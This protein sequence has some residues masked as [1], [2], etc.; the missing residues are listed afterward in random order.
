MD[1]SFPSQRTEG[2]QP[3]ASWAQS[4]LFLLRLTDELNCRDRSCRLQGGL[5]SPLGSDL[6][7][8]SPQVAS[9]THFLPGGAT[10]RMAVNG[11]DLCFP[12]GV[13][14]LPPRS[15]Q[16][17]WRLAGALNALGLPALC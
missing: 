17:Y 5:A 12:S 4:P 1:L 13:V 7:L 15:P 8:P 16:P 14:E 2:I 6:R 11:T 3:T 10:Q 9:L